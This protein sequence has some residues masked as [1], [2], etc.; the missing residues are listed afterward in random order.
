MREKKKK[1]VFLFLAFHL[2]MHYA[3]ILSLAVKYKI[4]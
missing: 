2:I 1:N 3:N 4:A